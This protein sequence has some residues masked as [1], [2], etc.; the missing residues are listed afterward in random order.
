MFFALHSI[1]HFSAKIL[2]TIPPMSIA[3][4]RILFEDDAL[5]VVNK[6][7][8]ELTVKAPGESK[9]LPLFDYLAKQFPGLRTV[10]RLDFATSGVIVFAKSRS[11][12]EALRESF[13]KWKKTYHALVH[14]SPPRKTGTIDTPLPSRQKGEKVPAKSTYRTLVH[15]GRQSLVE[16]VIESGRKHQVRLHM[17]S[18]GC[19]LVLDSEHGDSKLDRAF[20]K[21]FHFRRFFLH[22]VN[23][24]F[25][26]PL[27]GKM[28][29]INAPRPAVFDRL[30]DELR[31]Q[32]EKG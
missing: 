21:H 9:E 20:K 19:P 25:P 14:G 12:L 3:R 29:I 6:R 22:C 10:H 24:S 28:Q 7:A 17:A 11:V 1:L 2:H 15:F 8:G 16:V 13:P 27:T 31:D 26:H 30:L 5:L 32:H 23:L 4:N 18:I